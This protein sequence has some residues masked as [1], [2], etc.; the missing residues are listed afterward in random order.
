MTLFVETAVKY[1]TQNGTWMKNSGYEW[2]DYT[3]CMDHQVPDILS[4]PTQV[5]TQLCKNNV[6]VNLFH[7]GIGHL[8]FEVKCPHKSQ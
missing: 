8:P 6:E 1:C 5:T 2:T 4:L 7:F 3:P